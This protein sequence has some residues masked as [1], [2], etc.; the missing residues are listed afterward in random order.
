MKTLAD[1]EEIQILGTGEILTGSQIA[2]LIAALRKIS[3]NGSG[4][5]CGID[6]GTADEALQNANLSDP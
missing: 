2:G 6:Q 3:W 4:S 5:L 1:D